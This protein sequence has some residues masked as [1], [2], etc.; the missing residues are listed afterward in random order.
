MSINLLLAI[1]GFSDG[2]PKHISY[3]RDSIWNKS[4]AIS[5]DV[6]NS[7]FFLKRGDSSYFEGAPHF[8]LIDTNNPARTI[9]VFIKK[10]I[11]G[12]AIWGDTDYLNNSTYTHNG[13]E[14]NKYE[15]DTTLIYKISNDILSFQT[16]G[17]KPQDSTMLKKIIFS[18]S[19]INI[20]HKPFPSN[21]RFKIVDRK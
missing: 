12:L 18:T 21:R 17:F 15:N 14:V 19:L 2:N 13:Y 5:M 1:T 20:P 11:S 7:F 8:V 4:I 3:K 9:F 16:F 6:P 10:L